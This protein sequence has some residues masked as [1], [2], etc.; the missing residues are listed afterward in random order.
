MAG[1]S[2]KALKSQYVQNKYRDNSGNELQ[3]QELVMEVGW[4]YMMLFIGCMM[5]K[6]EGLGKK[7]NWV[8]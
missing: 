8:S 1:V 7:M 3:S 4:S 6:L 5:H 2:D